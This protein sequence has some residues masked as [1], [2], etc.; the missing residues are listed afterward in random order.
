MLHFFKRLK[1]EIKII[2][3]LFF[4][5]IV[6]QLICILSPYPELKQ[7]LEQP[8]SVVLTDRY[9]QNIYTVPLADG[10]RREYLAIGDIPL[11]VQKIYIKSEDKRFYFHPGVD[12]FSLI[13]AIIQNIQAKRI[14][15]GASTITMQLASLI[16]PR[17][18]SIFSKIWE[19][20]DALRLEARFSKKQILELYL[21]S[22]PFGFQAVGISS[23]AHTFYG[24]PLTSLSPE[25]ILSLAIIPRR[26]QL[27]NPY[28][29]SPQLVEALSL[30]GKRLGYSFTEAQLLTAL[31]QSSKPQWHNE[32][33]HF[34]NYV[35]DKLDKKPLQGKVITSLDLELN[36]LLND[37]LQF[38]LDEYRAHR[39]TNGA[40]LVIDNLTGEILVYIGSQNF[41]DDINSGQIDGIQVKNQPGSTIKPFL[42]ALALDKGYLPGD[43]L[44]DI[45]M[46]FGGEQVYLPFNFDR[47]YHGPV[48]LRVALASSLNIPAVYLST[49]I[50]TRN[51]VHKLI[52]LD[53]TSLRGK[54]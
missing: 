39:L 7:F 45:P 1:K 11:E 31:E 47:R 49:Q 32:A 29:Q 51:F 6:Y 22:I 23:A 28:D 42:Y 13:R 48:R 53:F 30:L 20:G 44:P 35:L 50:G 34:V 16:H 27:Y 12:L 5:I 38:Y 2:F 3:Y 17:N 41:Y 10:M 37:Q 25:Q 54:E 40:I 46:D 15:S 33:P 43:I 26:P 19:I 36:H 52:E 8:Y 24:Q 14:V 21:N 9:Q 4:I 18:T